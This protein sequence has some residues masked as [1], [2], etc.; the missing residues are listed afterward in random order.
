MIVTAVT[1]E[2]VTIY[3]VLSTNIR[4]CIQLATEN[5]TI[6]VVIIIKMVV[7]I[8]SYFLEQPFVFDC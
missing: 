2:I 3:I 8:Y 7:I 1:L 4:I 5:M 6:F